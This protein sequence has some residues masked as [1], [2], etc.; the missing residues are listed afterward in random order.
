M[1]EDDDLNF[2]LLHKCPIEELHKDCYILQLAYKGECQKI[3]STLT[4]QKTI[5]NMWHSSNMEVNKAR[6]DYCNYQH[7][8]AK[9]KDID[10]RV[11]H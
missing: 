6:R 8:S 2:K 7:R 10:F 4:V 1:K 9:A 11:W 3:V 5:H